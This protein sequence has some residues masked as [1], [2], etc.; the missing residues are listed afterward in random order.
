MRTPI[1]TT[2]PGSRVNLQSV[3]ARVVL[4]VSV[5]LL[6]FLTAA[7][8]AAGAA[9]SAPASS[10]A[11]FGVKVVLPG[12]KATVAGAIS[13]PPQGA[14]SVPSWGYGEGA[15]STGPISGGTR[16]DVEGGSA[17]AAADLSVAAVSLFAGEVTVG[18]VRL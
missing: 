9:S 2:M 16:S 3:P 15:V 11:A 10:A 14:A 8:G 7:G 6:V 17:S 4:G 18:S 12:G 1:M 5:L 13:S